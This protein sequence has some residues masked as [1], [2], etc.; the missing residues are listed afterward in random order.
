VVRSDGSGTTFQFK[1]Y[2]ALLSSEKGAAAMPCELTGWQERTKK[3]IEEGKKE[4]EVKTKLWANM[5]ANALAG[6]APNTT[7]PN[8]EK[9]NAGECA[10]TTTVVAQKGGGGVVKYV[11]EH[12][13]TI[14]YAALPD[15]KGTNNIEEKAQVAWLQ[16]NGGETT[17]Y[18][19]P[20][21]S[22]EKEEANCGSR[23]Y[24][25]P[26]GGREGESGEGIDWS[27]VFGAKPEIGGTAY[28]LC[29]LTYG[30][31][32]HSYEAAGYAEPGTKAEALIAYTK[33]VLGTGQ[34]LKHWY[35]AL[36][37][38]EAEAK[39]AEHNVLGA[40][41]LAMSKIGK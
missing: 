8:P 35:Q 41:K 7:W 38:P 13:G 3:E 33:Y 9:G 34:G 24:T 16:N 12:E 40:A 18:A 6:E 4:E 5:K 31:S 15:A 10:G 22:A 1:N 39:G 28:P 36:P 27:K 21:L 32:W 23:V 17:T 29:T 26:A 11:A 20:G 37:Q 25:V 30:L 19:N 2:L 14:G